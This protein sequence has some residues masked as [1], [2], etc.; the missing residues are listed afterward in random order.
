MEKLS[1]F[2]SQEKKNASQEKKNA[3]LRIRLAELDMSF[4]DLARQT[5]FH[6]VMVDPPNR[7]EIAR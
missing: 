6:P 5:G 1:S 4:A 7:N 3:A 2:R